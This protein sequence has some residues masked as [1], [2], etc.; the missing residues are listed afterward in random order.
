MIYTLWIEDIWREEIEEKFR[1]NVAFSGTVS[2]KNTEAVLG[3]LKNLERVND[4]GEVVKLLV[5]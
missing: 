5:A 2:E 1:G 3:I 4:I